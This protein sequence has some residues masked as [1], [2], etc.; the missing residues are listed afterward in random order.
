MR[1][2][3][4]ALLLAAAT[5]G[6]AKEAPL[7]G[8]VAEAAAVVDAFHAAL[9]RGDTRAASNLVE[10]EALIFESGAAEHSRLEY[11][12]HHLPADADFSKSVSSTVTRRSGG[13]D[14]A[15]AWIASEGGYRG[16]HHGKTL[17]Q[18]TTETMILRRTS[19]GWK[20]V[21]I[22]WSSAARR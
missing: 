11:E 17:D 20:I 4:A 15:L 10:A 16:T 18:V 7:S 14:G 1:V 12:A 6:Q 21:H 3:V 5:P 22:H 13:S 2:I 19:D 9:H 8:E